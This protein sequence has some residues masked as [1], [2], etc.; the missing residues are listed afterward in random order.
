M[1]QCPLLPSLFNKQLESLASATEQEKGERSVQ[2]RKEKIKLFLFEGDMIV[3]VENPNAA[4]KKFLELTSEFSK[5]TEYKIN[6]RAHTHT[7]MY[8]CIL[9]MNI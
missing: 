2:I 5:V 3:Y 6:E 1:Q 4:T 7:Q 8:F 9:A